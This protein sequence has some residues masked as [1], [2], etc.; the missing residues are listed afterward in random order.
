MIRAATCSQP[1]G[2]WADRRCAEGDKAAWNQT[3]V[4]F[5]AFTE[6]LELNVDICRPGGKG[7][8]YSFLVDGVRVEEIAAPPSVP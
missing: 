3:V 1:T 8:A 6:G 4:E 5:P 2:I 7:S